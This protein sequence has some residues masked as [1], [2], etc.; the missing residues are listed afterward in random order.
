MIKKTCKFCG[1][2]FF[3][4]NNRKSICCK[5]EQCRADLKD[6]WKIPRN[7]GYMSEEKKRDL[8]ELN[9]MRKQF[10]MKPVD[11]IP[12]ITEYNV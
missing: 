5:K 9:K 4:A 2:D 7:S 8:E 10:G 6:S 12:N 3:V 11:R 1:E